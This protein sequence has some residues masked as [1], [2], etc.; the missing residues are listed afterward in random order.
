MNPVD[1]RI[2]GEMGFK[3]SDY[4]GRNRWPSWI[5]R[6]VQERITSR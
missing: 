5:N 2:F 3:Y 4:M 6:L 1:L